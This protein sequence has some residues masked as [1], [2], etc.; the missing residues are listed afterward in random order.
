MYVDPDPKRLEDDDY[1]DE[2]YQQVQGSIQDGMDMLARRRSF[3][4]FG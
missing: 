3:P 1:I 2:V 4:L